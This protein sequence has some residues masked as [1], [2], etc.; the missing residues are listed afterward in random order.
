[1]KIKK[2]VKERKVKKQLQ[3]KLKVKGVKTYLG[4]C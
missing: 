3:R 1:M 2:K 4:L